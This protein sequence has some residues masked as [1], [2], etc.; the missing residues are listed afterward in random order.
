MAETARACEV[1]GGRSV[2]SL[3]EQAFALPGGETL[4]YRVVACDGCGF[5]FADGIPSPEEYQRYYAGNQRYT[6]EGSKN[7]PRGLRQTHE[8][9]FRAVDSF[10]RA[11]A[12]GGDRLGLTVLDMGCATGHLLSFFKENGYRHLTGVDPAPEC[13]E[14]ASRLYGID[15]E[16]SPLQEYRRTGWGLVVLSSVLEHLPDLAR[17]VRHIAG[18]VAPG[19][20]VAVQVPD[21][22]S[23]GVNLRE[24]FL[25]FSLEHINYFTRGSLRNVM[26]PAGFAERHHQV[27]LL[28]NQG[29]TFPALTTVWERTGVAG[30][31]TADPVGREAVTRYVARSR[32]VQATL[33]ERIDQLVSRGEDLAIWGAG[34]LTARLLATTRLG[35]ARIRAVV[36]ANPSLHGRSLAGV[37]IS[38]PDSLRGQ[39]LPVLVASYVYMDE[40]RS[41]LETDLRY[42][43]PIVTLA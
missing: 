24:P 31:V 15:V 17:S 23:F 38:P 9:I 13:R 11:R 4:R 29:T 10:L 37:P 35:Q 3:H 36:D 8:G 28:D 20:R 5:V 21:A 19:G 1:C 14:I 32:L 22:A 40:I 2:T 18:L 34:S 30:R 12:G 25:E 33:E 16:T 26:E 42:G 7:V 43:G 39:T 41:A 27:D 6:Y